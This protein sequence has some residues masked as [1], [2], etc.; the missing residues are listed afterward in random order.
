MTAHTLPR[1][2]GILLHPTS[3]PG[4]FGIGDLGPFAYRWVE[5]LVA[6]RQSWWQILPLGPTGAGD[7]PYQSFSA[8]AGNISLLSPELLIADG[9]IST[10]HLAGQTFTDESVDYSRVITLKKSLLRVAWDSFRGGKAPKLKHDFDLYCEREKA[11]LH[12]FA[13]FMA[14]RESLG[15]RGLTAWPADLLK[16]NPVALGAMEKELAAEIAMHKLGQFLF[17][18]QWSAVRTFAAE[19]SV[20]IIGD[21]PIFVS[22]DSA[23]VWAHAD[24]FLLTPD[25]L[26]NVVAGVPPDYFS[27]DGQHWGNPLYDWNRMAQTGYSWW[28]ARMKRQLQQVDIVRL[29]HF[30]GFAQA[31]HIPASEATAKNGKWVDGPGAKLFEKLQ[32][33]LGGLPLIAEDLGLITPDVDALRD[34]FRL[35]GMKVIQFALDTPLN[36]YWPHNFEPNCVCY[37]GTHDNDTTNGW[38]ATLDAKSRNYLSEYIGRPVQDAARDLIRLAWSSVAAVAI[39]PLQD[40]M[41]LGNDARM[42]RPGIAEGNWKWRFRGDQFRQDQIDRIS[43][44][45]E[46]YNRLPQKKPFNDPA[47]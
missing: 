8:F 44:L 16:R 4:P 20:R 24:E 1:S 28:V 32:S 25:R 39:A 15:G 18:R 11:W 10:S 37:T 31:W 30:R 46:L 42:N 33:A 36:P 5:T 12:D 38:W 3:L 34:G 22:L 17:D 29:D 7:S 19:R 41:G 35:P 21:A 2:S 47:A 6:M 43:G 26:P 40:V 45:T 9:L 14:I 23:D 13:L 27:A